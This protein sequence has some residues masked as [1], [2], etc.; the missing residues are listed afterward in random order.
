VWLQRFALSG[1]SRVLR[2]EDLLVGRESHRGNE[3][4]D[5]K[6]RGRVREFEIETDERGLC[7]SLLSVTVTMA[8]ERRGVLSTA[9]AIGL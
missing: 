1:L 9:E 4:R 6:D 7:S 8:L 3:L 2:G 5:F